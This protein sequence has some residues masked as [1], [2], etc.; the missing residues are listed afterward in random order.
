MEIYCPTR[1]AVRERHKRAATR[2]EIQSRAGL[3]EFR[4]T[5]SYQLA[6]VTIVM[7]VFKIERDSRY[8]V[9][10]SVPGWGE[11][12]APTSMDA[13]LFKNW[14]PWTMPVDSRTKRRGDFLFF[15]LEMFICS[16]A[17]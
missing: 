6:S 5:K 13:P 3:I 17:L 1:N 7:K 16:R 2:S 15:P 9:I 10:G 8:Q 4:A 12:Y 11:R 14:E